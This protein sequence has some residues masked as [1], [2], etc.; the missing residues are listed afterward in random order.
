MS[1]KNDPA[2]QKAS[3]DMLG[4]V[5]KIKETIR[6]VSDMVDSAGGGWEGAAKQAFDKVH[7]D[8]D[9]SA[10]KLNLRLDEIANNV[11]SGGKKLDATETNSAQKIAA[12]GS[13]L[14]MGTG[15]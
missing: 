6:K 14:N 7:A 11:G 9:H 12:T 3:S 5:A 13:Q 10:L 8:W 4:S 2:S 15:A 1:V